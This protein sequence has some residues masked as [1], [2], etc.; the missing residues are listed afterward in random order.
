MLT[1]LPFIFSRL[2]LAAE[3]VLFVLVGA[4]VDVGYTIHAGGGVL[5]L[6]FAGLAFRSVGVLLSMTG[7][8]LNFREKLFCVISYLPKATVQAAIGGMPLS[9]GLPCGNIVLTIAVISILL[10]APMG[11]FGMDATYRR[12][13]HGTD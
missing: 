7:T 9:L 8:G 11:A 10:T 13:L 12:L 5:V 4:A 6:L 2:W 1:S 3:V